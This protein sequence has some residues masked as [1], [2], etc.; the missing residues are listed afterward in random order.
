V[1]PRVP[2]PAS[3]LSRR[4]P[5]HPSPIRRLLRLRAHVR[6][7]GVRAVARCLDSYSTWAVIVRARQHSA[8]A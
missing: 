8:R 6:F 5:S 7:A 3:T 4:R 2:R 1:I